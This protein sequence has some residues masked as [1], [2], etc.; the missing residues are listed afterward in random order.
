VQG[1]YYRGIHPQEVPRNE[2]R[3]INVGEPTQPLWQYRSLAAQQVLHLHGGLLVLVVERV[4]VLLRYG[5]WLLR[6]G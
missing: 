1:E 6:K 3:D 2:R 4:D 5:D